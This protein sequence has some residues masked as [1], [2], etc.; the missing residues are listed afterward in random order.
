MMIVMF[1]IIF[2]LWVKYDIISKKGAFSKVLS[3]AH[4][5]PKGLISN[6]LFLFTTISDYKRKP[7]G[8]HLSHNLTPLAATFLPHFFRN[9]NIEKGYLNLKKY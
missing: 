1:Q 6:G 5:R 2:Y 7:G 4:H 8:T 9:I 3:V